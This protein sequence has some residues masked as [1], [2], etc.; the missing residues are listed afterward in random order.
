VLFQELHLLQV[1]IHQVALSL[2]DRHLV[3]QNVPPRP[4][5]PPQD[6][7]VL[8]ELQA[9]SVCRAEGQPPDLLALARG[10]PLQ[11]SELLEHVLAL[12]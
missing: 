12:V 8:A 7:R 10:Q 1:P 5:R 2:G 9:A 11:R 4:V 3:L 6:P